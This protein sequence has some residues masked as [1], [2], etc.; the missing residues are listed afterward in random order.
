MGR[1]TT[2]QADRPLSSASPSHKGDPGPQDHHPCQVAEFRFALHCCTHAASPQTEP[3]SLLATQA[4]LPQE[5]PHAF[6]MVEW[7]ASTAP[8]VCPRATSFMATVQEASMPKLMRTSTWREKE[9]ERVRL[10]VS[11]CVCVSM[12]ACACLPAHVPMYLCT[13]TCVH[14]SCI[15]L[16]VHASASGLGD[17]A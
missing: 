3:V 1:G 2:M 10:C 14:S 8:C 6:W 17:Y 15:R 7:T 4:A 16:H 9:R 12:H 11:A 5:G 13:C